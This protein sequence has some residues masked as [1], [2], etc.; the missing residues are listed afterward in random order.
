MFL[1]HFAHWGHSEL[2]EMNTRELHYWHIEAVNLYNKLNKNAE[3][4]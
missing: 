2:M 4:S 3:G 1:A